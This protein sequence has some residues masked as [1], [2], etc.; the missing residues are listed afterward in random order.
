MKFTILHVYVYMFDITEE[1]LISFNEFY[2]THE[3]SFAASMK[4]RFC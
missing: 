2:L 1:L 4:E 3:W